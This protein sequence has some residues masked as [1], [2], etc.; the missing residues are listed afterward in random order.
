[1]PALLAGEQRRLRRLDIRISVR[2]QAHWTNAN[3]VDLSRAQADVAYSFNE[4]DCSAMRPPT[5]CD[6]QSGRPAII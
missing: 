3:A 5:C 6:R 2:V 4:F 1:V